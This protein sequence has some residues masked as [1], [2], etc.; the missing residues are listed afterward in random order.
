MKGKHGA[1]AERK[2]EREQAALELANATRRAERA[3]A[4][5]TSLAEKLRNL[6]EMYKRDVRDLRKQVASQRPPQMEVL[7]QENT[8][9]VEQIDA[10]KKAYRAN[11]RT[12]AE[13]YVEAAAA[14]EA[15]GMSELE[16]M[17]ALGGS[18]TQT[19]YLGGHRAEDLVRAV[20]ARRGGAHA[21]VHMQDKLPKRSDMLKT[22]DDA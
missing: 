7:E 21:L 22:L 19:K 10:L 8:R 15:T 9:L 16:V 17:E 18:R 14:M 6:D 5:A 4:E 12:C 1:I 11:E 3:E 20:S 2:R 13:W